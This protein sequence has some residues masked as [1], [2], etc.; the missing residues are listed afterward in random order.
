LI[1]A[2]RF[3]N[4]TGAFAGIVKG[5]RVGHVLVKSHGD[6]PPAPCS[7]GIQGASEPTAV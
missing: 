5:A 4:S 3:V 2:S 6:H 7:P 1:Q